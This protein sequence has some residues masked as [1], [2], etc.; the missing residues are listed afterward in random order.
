MEEIFRDACSA[1]ASKKKA[2]LLDVSLTRVY[3]AGSIFDKAEVMQAKF[4]Q[5]H[6]IVYCGRGVVVRLARAAHLNRSI[7][8]ALMRQG[9]V[10]LPAWTTDIA[11]PTAGGRSGGAWY[12]TATA[13]WGKGSDAGTI[14]GPGP[15]VPERGS[16]L[17]RVDEV[18]NAIE[19]VLEQAGR[20]DEP[21]SVFGYTMMARGESFV[22]DKRVPSHLVLFMTTGASFD[23]LVQTAGRATFM[24][25]HLLGDNGWV[26]EEDKPVVRVLMPEQDFKVIQ[27]YPSLIEKVDEHVKGGKSLEELF[28]ED[29]VLKDIQLLQDFAASHRHGFGDKRKQFPTSWMGGGDDGADVDGESLTAALQRLQLPKPGEL[30]WFDHAGERKWF[31]CKVQRARFSDGAHDG[32]GLV[33]AQDVEYILVCTDRSI[34]LL[35]DWVVLDEQDGN[36][37]N[38]RYDKPDSSCGEIV[39]EPWVLQDIS[40]IRKVVLELLR[41]QGD[42]WMTATQIE[43]LMKRAADGFSVGGLSGAELRRCMRED[44][45]LPGEAL[46]WL[47]E[48]DQTILRRLCAE[49]GYPAEPLE[50]VPPAKV[51][52]RS[53]SRSGT[54]VDLSSPPVPGF[55]G[56]IIKLEG[57]TSEPASDFTRKPRAWFKHLQIVEWPVGSP[58]DHPIAYDDLFSSGEL[59]VVADCEGLFEYRYT[60]GSVASA[61]SSQG[62]TSSPSQGRGRRSGRP[63][64]PSPLSGQRRSSS[65]LSTRKRSEHQ[66]QPDLDSVLDPD[67]IQPVDMRVIIDDMTSPSMHSTLIGLLKLSKLLSAADIESLNARAGS[68]ASERHISY[69]LR[70]ACIDRCEP[71]LDADSRL[72]WQTFNG[73][74]RQAFIHLCEENAVDY[75]GSN[76]K[77]EL[78]R[79]VRETIARKRAERPGG[80]QPSE[81]G[82]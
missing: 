65:R 46:L 23:T 36:R 72:K 48:R 61:P 70:R 55:K 75:E 56:P 41:Q 44:N 27:G 5:M 1:D 16:R 62:S 52:L 73:L 39:H 50:S 49:R 40:K 71:H 10:L 15:L 64:D 45:T 35:A 47:S 51:Q 53:G 30:I 20:G 2:L 31:E 21:I 80:G 79:L 22:T 60:A 34:D 66:T 42:R 37:P 78:A 29:S 76:S 38:W 69:E 18:L 74:G 67:F 54:I 57:G 32:D 19:C 26:D 81:H 63:D 13:D 82:R 9:K 28:G 12:T 77:P 4:P 33:G 25:Q 6:V 43:E 3:V 58:L 68:N 8:V 7:E 17:A 59:P 11:A 24:R 14:I